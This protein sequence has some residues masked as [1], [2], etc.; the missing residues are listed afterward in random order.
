MNKTLARIKVIL[1]ALPTWM[2]A[3][4]VTITALSP[5]IARMFPNDAETVARVAVAVVAGLASAIAI[6][7]K[8]AP[9]LPDQVGI[10]PQ[11]PPAS[12]VV[13]ID[14]TPPVDVPKNPEGA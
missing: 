3:I 2:T 10:L 14:Q 11:G 8:V 13:V 5:L 9:V 1:T 12:P 6:I 7:R 4:A